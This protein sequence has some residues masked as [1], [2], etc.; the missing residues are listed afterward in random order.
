M[1]SHKRDVLQVLR[2]RVMFKKSAV[3]EKLELCFYNSKEIQA[4][5]HKAK[6]LLK[7]KG[8]PVEEVYMERDIVR[9]NKKKDFVKFS[10]E[11]KEIDKKYNDVQTQIRLFGVPQDILSILESF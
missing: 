3:K 11:L 5:C 10:N 6:K 2:E 1:S 4:M 7:S 8:Y 9:P